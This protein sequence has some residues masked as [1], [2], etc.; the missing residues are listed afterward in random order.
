LRRA[1]DLRARARE[2]INVAQRHIARASVDRFRVLSRDSRLRSSKIAAI[3]EPPRYATLS[4]ATDGLTSANFDA[5]C[6]LGDCTTPG[7]LRSRVAERPEL[8]IT[9]RIVNSLEG[10]PA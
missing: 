4:V 9:R 5:R 10:A 1:E 8:G 2:I 7:T 6:F 3:A